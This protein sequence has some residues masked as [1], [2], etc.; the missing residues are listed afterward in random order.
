MVALLRE[1]RD[2]L[3]EMRGTQPGQ[4]PKNFTEPLY[5][6]SHGVA[7]AIQARSWDGDLDRA[8]HPREG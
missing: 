2:L 7:P 6:I 3:V 1:I 5:P 8:Y 4:A